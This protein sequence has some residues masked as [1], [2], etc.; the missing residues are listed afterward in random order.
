MEWKNKNYFKDF[1]F[2]SW[3]FVING[4]VPTNFVNNELANKLRNLWTIE[5]K[6]KVKLGVKTKYLMVSVLRTKEY[7][8]GFS[9]NTAKKEWK[10]FEIIYEDKARMNMFIE[11]N[12][13]PMK[14]KVTFKNGS[15]I[16]R[17]VL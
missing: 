15:I 13:T 11:E 7:F 10:T 5:D 12:D 16:L 3:N 6:V 2:E 4:L 14:V 9:C 1:H 17:M 8:N